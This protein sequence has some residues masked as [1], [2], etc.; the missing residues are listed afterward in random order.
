LAI[1]I[2]GTSIIDSRIRR[3]TRAECQPKILRYF[4]SQTP[5]SAI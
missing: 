1:K 3:V 5:R 2:R 4:L